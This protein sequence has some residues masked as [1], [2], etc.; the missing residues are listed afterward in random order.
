MQ[1]D[2]VGAEAHRASE[3]GDLLLLGQQVDHR[4]LGLDVELGGVRAGHVR[5]VACELADGHLHPQA[6]PEIRDPLLARDADGADLALDPAPSEA[7]G[8]EDP[9]HVAEQLA[10]MLVAVELLRVDPLDHDVAAVEVAAVTQR[11]GDGLVG[12]LE[13]DVLADE[14][15]PHGPHG[16]LG[17]QDHFLPFREVGRRRIEAQRARR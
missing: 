6:D 2:R 16:P 11:L 7:A 5:D 9:V 14:R 1:L 12:V 17:A 15:D 3:V 13:L 4:P 8:N 10:G